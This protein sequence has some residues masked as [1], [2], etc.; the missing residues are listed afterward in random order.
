V[1]PA[2]GSENPAAASTEGGSTGDSMVVLKVDPDK[3]PKA[4]DLKAHLFPSTLCIAISDQE[5][6]FV[7]R[8][9]FPNLSLSAGLAPIAAA[10]PAVR[11]LIEHGKP[12][13]D[14]AAGSPAVAGGAPGQTGSQPAA[15]AAAAPRPPR[16]QPA[17]SKGASPA[18]RGGSTGQLSPN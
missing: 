15:N 8:G 14:G 1:V 11:S 13:Q 3:L 10:L 16:G 5:I 2:G 17:T 4:A 12:P 6:R 9:A 7:S 18:A